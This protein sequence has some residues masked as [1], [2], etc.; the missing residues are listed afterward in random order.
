LAPATTFSCRAILAVVVRADGVARS[1]IATTHA[2]LVS[3]VAERMSVA[4]DARDVTSVA[5]ANVVGGI[6]VGHSHAIKECVAR[7][8]SPRH[9]LTAVAKTAR[10]DTT[11]S[12]GRA[13]LAIAEVWSPKV[14]VTRDVIRILGTAGACSRYTLLFF[15]APAAARM[16]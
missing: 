14:N 12:A 8:A 15:A 1:A 7:R 6:A 9:G 3:L 13:A 5:T 10:A 4:A 2:T 11:V 16:C